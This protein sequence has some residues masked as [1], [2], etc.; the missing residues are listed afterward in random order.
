M[1]EYKLKQ[2]N[3]DKS[4][5]VKKSLKYSILD[6]T[7]FSMMVGFGESFFS[8]FAVFLKATNMQLG[9]LG[10]LPQALGSLSQL[11]SNKL[12]ELFKSRKK[13]VYIGALL[14]GLMYIPI[15]LVFFFGTFRVFHLVL[16]VCL[17]WIFGM[18]ISP[19]WNS[20]MGDLVHEKERGI[21]FGRR[22]R[23]T[24]LILF[25]SLLMGGLILQ[26]FTDGTIK[27]YIGFIII[28]SIALLA[29]V[30]SFLYLTKKY[31]PKYTIVPEAQ[32]SF[33]DFLKQARSRNFGLFVLYLCFMNF[34]VFFA[35]PFFT[36]YML[37][38]L[39]LNYMTF[40]IINATALIIKYLSM[41]VWGKSSDKYGTKKILTLTGFLMPL[42]PVL[43]LFSK[44][45]L[46]LILIQMYSGFVWA[47]FEISSFNFVFDTT[48]PAKRATCV[49]YYNVLNGVAIFIGA[50]IGG[51]IVK[52]NNVFWSKY[53]FV[54]LLSG[55]LRYLAS[56]AF[57]PKIR[58][59]RSVEHIPYHKL[60]FQII[61][62]M[63]TAGLIYNLVVFMKKKKKRNK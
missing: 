17:Y 59:V 22:N 18:I 47:G 24:G 50:M 23:I 35:A 41:P 46:Y 61:T 33:I 1:E 43:W 25:F 57:I 6:G 27:E 48:T 19:A 12:I 53:L 13:F 10:S 36:A 38:D 56:F 55:L 39:K 11:F 54:F 14:E 40:T 3:R 31:E 15:A 5:L 42:I 34:S 8:A 2:N 29:R 44:D 4:Y 60:F 16:F 30:V 9:L 51:I 62:T 49:A 58:E 21:Y 52:Y 37:Y 32:F 45:T 26:R 20:W 63:P 7:F 28:F